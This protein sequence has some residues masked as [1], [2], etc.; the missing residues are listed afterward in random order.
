M[1]KIAFFDVGET[2]IHDGLPF[3][4]VAAAL[5]AV[6]KFETAEDAPLRMGIIS[7]YHMP[8]PPI[9]EE[10]VGVLESQYRDEVLGPSGLAAFF[11]PF[12][13]RVTISSRAGTR[14]PAR[15]IFDVAVSRMGTGASLNECLF[16]TEDLDHLQKCKEHGIV[17]IRFGPDGSGMAGF[18]DWA[19][20]AGVIAGIVPQVTPATCL[21]RWPRRSPLG[22]VWLSST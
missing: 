11:E 14:K 5:T 8:T 1:I 22:M 6:A 7:D 20:A 13:S 21:R 19:D 2:L 15:K 4:G 10:K 9:T 18:E 12:E 17:P 3:P 16:V